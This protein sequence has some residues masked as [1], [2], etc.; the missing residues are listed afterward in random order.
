MARDKQQADPTANKEMGA[1][2]H[3]TGID[4]PSDVGSA[5]LYSTPIHDE[6]EEAEEAGRR[7]ANSPSR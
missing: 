7:K 4:E 6:G 1:A 2:G 5:G 3:E